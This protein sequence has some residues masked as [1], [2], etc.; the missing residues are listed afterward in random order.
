MFQW[1]QEE[2]WIEESWK[3]DTNLRTSFSLVFD[4]EIASFIPENLPVVSDNTHMILNQRQ[5]YKELFE[6]FES[7][8]PTSLTETQP[9]AYSIHSKDQIV[10]K[11][12]PT[13]SEDPMQAV[14]PTGDCLTP[15]A[16]CLKLLPWFVRSSSIFPLKLWNRLFVKIPQDYANTLISRCIATILCGMADIEFQKLNKQKIDDEKERKENSKKNAKGFAS[17]A[18]VE[19]ALKKISWST[20]TTDAKTK[21]LVSNHDQLL[22]KN[23]PKVDASASGNPFKSNMTAMLAGIT[24]PRLLSKSSASSNST[25]KTLMNLNLESPNFKGW[26]KALTDD[27]FSEL[28]RLVGIILPASMIE[29]VINAVYFTWSI[30]VGNF[31]QK[32]PPQDFFQV[33]NILCQL[34]HI[35]S[36]QLFRIIPNTNSPSFNEKHPILAHD[37]QTLD[38]M[39]WEV[40]KS[41]LSELNHELEKSKKLVEET[42]NKLSQ[43]MSLNPTSSNL[44]ELKKRANDASQSYY[45]IREKFVEREVLEFKELSNPN[46]FLQAISFWVHKVISTNSKLNV[47]NG[48]NPDTTPPYKPC[49]AVSESVT[50]Q[51]G[52]IMIIRK[53]IKEEFDIYQELPT[54]LSKLQNDQMNQSS[55]KTQMAEEW[56]KLNV[57]IESIENLIIA[58]KNTRISEKYITR[59]PSRFVQWNDKE[60]VWEEYLCGPLIVCIQH[61]KSAAQIHSKVKTIFIEDLKIP[62]HDHIEAKLLNRYVFMWRQFTEFTFYSPPGKDFVPIKQRTIVFSSKTQPECSVASFHS[63]ANNST[64]HIQSENLMGYENMLP[65]RDF[66]PGEIQTYS[67]TENEHDLVEIKRDHV[68]VGETVQSLYPED[69]VQE[70]S[71]LF[72]DWVSAK[73]AK[74]KQQV[75]DETVQKAS[76]KTLLS[77]ADGRDVIN[78]KQ[79]HTDVNACWEKF[80]ETIKTAKTQDDQEAKVDPSVVSGPT[81][82]FESISVEMAL[83][84]NNLDETIKNLTKNKEKTEAE[85]KK[86]LQKVSNGI[87]PIL[88]KSINAELEEL[89]VKYTA[90]IEEAKTLFEQEQ[91]KMTN[92]VDWVKMFPSPV[93]STIKLHIDRA[94]SQ[95]ETRKIIELELKNRE[96]S[97]ATIE[98]TFREHEAQLKELIMTLSP[99]DKTMKEKLESKLAQLRQKAEQAKKDIDEKSVDD[100]FKSTLQTKISGL[101]QNNVSS[102]THVLNDLLTTNPLFTKTK[103]DVLTQLKSVT[104]ELQK[105][106]SS[107]VSGSTS[108]QQTICKEPKK[109]SN[110]SDLSRWIS[111]TNVFKQCNV[112]NLKIKEARQKLNLLLMDPLINGV[113]PTSPDVVDTLRNNKQFI[114]QV[115]SHH[116]LLKEL[117]KLNQ[118]RKDLEHVKNEIIIQSGKEPQEPSSTTDPSQIETYV[119]DLMLYM[120]FKQIEQKL[121]SINRESSEITNKMRSTEMLVHQD[122]IKKQVFYSLLNQLIDNDVSVHPS[123]SSVVTSTN[124][125]MTSTNSSINTGIFAKIKPLSQQ[126]AK[127]STNTTT[128]NEP[129]LPNDPNDMTQV[130]TWVEQRKAYQ[131]CKATGKRI[132]SL[133]S[134]ISKLMAAAK[135]NPSLI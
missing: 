74:I 125:G 109:P 66:I 132:D 13:F 24:G 4:N 133:K 110:V 79:H 57:S 45:K 21:Q 102:S 71:A 107:D 108:F 121:K 128:C 65:L 89:Q 38:L 80:K 55:E 46:T 103:D 3:A 39:A 83:L 113:L 49:L 58:L 135:A 19:N 29:R 43:E 98:K 5:T 126:L 59:S 105:L 10:L 92:Q 72:S 32:I 7:S 51:L 2:H 95:I 77:L 15:L 23:E 12:P 88:E 22:K 53:S 42:K 11:R 78:L 85:L 118:E 48:L 61:A 56:V 14:S 106:T 94:K 90:D 50:K 116:K 31:E 117:Q 75:L 34:I 54:K 47:S 41:E 76:L 131:D 93:A 37:P 87:N 9:F 112:K 1:P 122:E 25:L 16:S 33:T 28:K 73:F 63:V 62:L 101:I 127:I 52:L 40:F 36:N 104:D 86:V 91:L 8:V 69:I 6:A 18:P 129:S 130:Q 123:S 124:T 26:D 96:R 99:I 119:K 82:E 30:L 70:E 134:Q 111:Q 27:V 97:K 60:N 35:P 68:T 20:D 44:P 17:W 84:K 100:S 67:E 81:S 120:K 64:I 115:H 114:Q